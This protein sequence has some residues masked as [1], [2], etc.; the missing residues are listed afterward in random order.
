MVKLFTFLATDALFTSKNLMK[1]VVV[2]ASHISSFS[3]LESEHA[4]TN[5]KQKCLFHILVFSMQ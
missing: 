4:R 3:Q 1:L 5:K 2:L